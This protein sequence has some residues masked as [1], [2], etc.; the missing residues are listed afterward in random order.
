MTIPE[1]MHTLEQTGSGG[2]EALVHHT[3]WLARKTQRQYSCRDG[4]VPF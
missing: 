4:V 2:L 3:D 1:T